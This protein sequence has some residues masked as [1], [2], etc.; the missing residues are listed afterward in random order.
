MQCSRKEK[1][2]FARTPTSECLCLYDTQGFN[3]PCPFY[4]P[5]TYDY[6]VVHTFEGKTGNWKA[7][8]GF[9]GRY[10]VSDRGEVITKTMLTMRQGKGKQGGKPFVMLE[11]FEGYMRCYVEDLVATSFCGITG[12]V[13]H[14]DL[15]ILN[16][17]A[18]NLRRK[19]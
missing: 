10:F 11:V 1:D 8:Q 16:N 3:R 5:S 15:N 19:E 18:E 7:I 9:K 6:S 14:I 12:E 4:K 2:C 17:S 13:E